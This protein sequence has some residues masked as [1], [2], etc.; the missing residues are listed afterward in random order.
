[1][2]LNPLA[3]PTSG[4]TQDNQP[5]EE[6]QLSIDELSDIDDELDSMFGSPALML[7]LVLLGIGFGVLFY[8]FSRGS[9]ILFD[10]WA[11]GLGWII[12]PTP[13]LIFGIV[14]FLQ[15]ERGWLQQA[16]AAALGLA[17]ANYVM[18]AIEANT[19]G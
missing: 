17:L 9:M 1:M 13:L 16:G 7:L 12:A 15:S 3:R 2:S 18:M 11:D 5:N 10:R 6:D 14:S 8:S 4:M 19:S